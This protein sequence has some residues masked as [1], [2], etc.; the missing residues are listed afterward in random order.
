VTA[1]AVE[2]EESGT[3]SAGTTRRT[4]S[5]AKLAANRAN[6]RLSTGPRT[7]DGKARS[8]R[9][10]TCHGLTGKTWWA[11]PAVLA[12]V[13]RLG[14]R[15]AGNATGEEEEIAYQMAGAQITVM[16]ARAARHRLV[17]EFYP[18][19]GR[20]SI[21]QDDPEAAIERLRT[22]FRQLDAIERYESRAFRQRERACDRLARL[23]TGEPPK[24]PRRR[25]MGV[26]N[27]AFRMP[28]F[29]TI[30]FEGWPRWL[31]WRPCP[32][33]AARKKQLRSRTRKKPAAKKIPERGAPNIPPPS[34]ASGPAAATRTVPIDEPKPPTWI[35]KDLPIDQTKP[36]A[37]SRLPND[38]T[39]PPVVPAS[40]VPIDGTNP[41]VVPASI[42]AIDATNPPSGRGSNPR[43][44]TKPGAPVSKMPIDEPNSPPEDRPLATRKA[45]Q[46]SARCRHRPALR[47]RHLPQRGHSPPPSMPARR[48]D[49][50]PNAPPL[51]APVNRSR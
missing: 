35:G 7:A 32:L 19:D 24:L 2:P 11:D 31:W 50:W 10:R 48:F 12:A 46:T 13:E 4:I 44:E 18:S 5:A 8:A 20:T 38:G 9:N 1:T 28:S 49:R 36:S 22:A 14:E 40:T 45:S 41:P 25:G 3:R 21:H 27:P 30:R 37:G 39:N 6:A 43:V 15:I 47:T 33:E 29:E 51:R 34:R 42:V 26:R 16:R 17:A 23:R